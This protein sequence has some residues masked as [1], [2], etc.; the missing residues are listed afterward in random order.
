MDQYGNVIQEIIEIENSADD[1]KGKNVKETNKNNGEQLQQVNN[2][3]EKEKNNKPSVINGYQEHQEGEKYKI[4]KTKSLI[5]EQTELKNEKIEQIKKQL[6]IDTQWIKRV[7][8]CLI[9]ID[10]L[11]L[12]DDKIK[13][14]EE[15]E[16]QMSID[17]ALPKKQKINTYDTGYG[18]AGYEEYLEK[19]EKRRDDE[20]AENDRVKNKIDKMYHP[21]KYFSGYVYKDAEEIQGYNDFVNNRVDLLKK[22]K[23]YQDGLHKYY[24]GDGSNNN[25]LPYKYKDLLKD[26]K[27]YI[28]LFDDKNKKIDD[29]QKRMI[30]R[31]KN[32]IKFEDERFNGLKGLKANRLITRDRYNEIVADHKEKIKQEK[33]EQIRNLEDKWNKYNISFNNGKNLLMNSRNANK[34][35]KNMFAKLF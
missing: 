18:P 10:Q 11:F 23:Q 5:K 7:D 24:Y 14:Q 32:T 9:K 29:K 2:N 21:Y 20:E 15:Q 19:R 33:E 4:K 30:D 31:A 27:E 17:C 1:K 3:Q 25:V 8:E 16:K 26:R 34:K 28:K 13:Q 35:N 12:P 22:Q 6:E